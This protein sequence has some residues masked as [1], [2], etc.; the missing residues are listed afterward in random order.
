[1]RLEVCDAVCGY[2]TKIVVENINFS[3]QSGEILCLLGP[4][5][6]ENNLFKSILG[7]IKM[8]EAL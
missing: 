2:G 8:L 7:L 3:V 5:G 4:N 1:M 6:G